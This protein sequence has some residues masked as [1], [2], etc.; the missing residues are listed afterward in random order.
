M[1]NEISKESLKL[2]ILHHKVFH[3][4]FFKHFIK[5]EN[6][7]NPEKSSFQKCWVFSQE[8]F[9]YSFCREL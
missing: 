4:N 6:R 9:V 7:E 2:E 1:N 8:T 3:S 5:D